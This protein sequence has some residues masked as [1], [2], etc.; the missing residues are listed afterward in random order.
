MGPAS[1]PPEL[2]PLDELVPDPEPEPDPDPEL[3]ELPAP[4]LPL[5]DELPPPLPLEDDPPLEPL[6]LP[7]ID[8]S[9]LPLTV[10]TCPSCE[11]PGMKTSA[12]AAKSAVRAV[13][14]SW[15]STPEAEEAQPLPSSP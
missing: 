5:L 8:A 10:E 1:A 12:V 2:P 14:M 3:V 4:L 7:V 6:E 9:G 11:Q 15:L 13:P